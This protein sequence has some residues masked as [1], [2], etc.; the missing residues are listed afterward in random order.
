M[1]EDRDCFL[2]LNWFAIE[3]RRNPQPRRQ[4]VSSTRCGSREYCLARMGLFTTCLRS[5]RRC[6]S[7]CRMG[8][9]WLERWLRCSIG[10]IGQIGPITPDYRQHEK[11]LALFEEVS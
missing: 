4:L 1:S 9:D 6:L 5:D 8:I 11:S 3:I 7:Q 2:E 10:P